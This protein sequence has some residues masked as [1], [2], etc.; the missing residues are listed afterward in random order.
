MTC[1]PRDAI[2]D[3]YVCDSPPIASLTAD[4]IGG[5]AVAAERENR[6][7]GSRNARSERSRVDR[8][9]LDG[10][11]AGYERRPFGL[12]DGILERSR[13]QIEIAGMKRVHHGSEVRP[14]PDRVL[15]PDG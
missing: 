2:D 5:R 10:R 3:T 4:A 12:G 11:Q 13:Q 14:L 6:R 7:A 1:A 9:L 15:E 8:R